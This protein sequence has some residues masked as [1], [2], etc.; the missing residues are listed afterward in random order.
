MTNGEKFKE[1][2]GKDI[3]GSK[4]IEPQ[5]L[6]LKS[7]QINGI[8][9]MEEWLNAEYKEPSSSENPIQSTTKNSLAVDCIDRQAAITFVCKN[10]KEMLKDTMPLEVKL[11]D[12][13]LYENV[14]KIMR[15]PKVLTSVIPIRPKGHW[16]EE[17]NDYGEIE[18]WHCSNCYDD[19]GFITTC[20]WDYC[21]NCGADMSEVEE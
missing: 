2:F 19:T 9:C 1:V 8:D 18:C 20:A 10:T 6:A 16:I 5:M 12:D 11:S 4:A 14:A 7:A 3:K 17:R 15:N 13:Y 21:P